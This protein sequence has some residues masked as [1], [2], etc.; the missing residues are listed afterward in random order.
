M[1][2]ALIPFCVTQIGLCTL[3][4][5]PCWRPRKHRK[6]TE[7][8]TGEKQLN[9]PHKRFLNLFSYNI[10]NESHVPGFPQFPFKYLF[11]CNAVLITFFAS[12]IN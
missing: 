10:F 1:V 4:E 8:I 2:Q 11:L 3:R 6:I 9:S 12:L 7:T 5:S